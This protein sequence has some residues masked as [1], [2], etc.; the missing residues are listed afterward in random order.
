MNQMVPVMKN[1]YTTTLS[2]AHK[3][4]DR[5]SQRANEVKAQAVKLSE[6]ISMQGYTDTQIGR[7][8]ANGPNAMNLLE[9]FTSMMSILTM[10]RTAIG[11][12]NM[13]YGISDL[14]AEI[15]SNKK[16]INTYKE[17]L[18]SQDDDGST[19]SLEDVRQYKSLTAEGTTVRHLAVTVSMLSPY[20]ISAMK[21]K[22]TEFEKKN[23][24]LGDKVSD[25]NDKKVELEFEQDIA[26]L[27]GF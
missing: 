19:L 1:K 20:Q 16:V 7:L 12:A 18:G 5:L 9:E 4:S 24:I 15:E 21:E 8:S 11:R 27:L 13:L 10:V 3:I 6:Q 23:F 17:I 2:R 14:L 25:L 26:Q 22:L